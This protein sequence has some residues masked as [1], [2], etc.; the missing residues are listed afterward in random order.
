MF[1]K[2]ILAWEW[3]ISYHCIYHSQ[4][5]SSIAHSSLAGL[6]LYGA[7]ATEDIKKASKYILR[8]DT[9]VGM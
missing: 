7:G 5:G 3:Y 4:L 6:H 8:M 1:S 2:D 9:K